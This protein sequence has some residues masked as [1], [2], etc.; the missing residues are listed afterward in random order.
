MVGLAL[1]EKPEH[2]NI[3]VAKTNSPKEPKH[4][5]QIYPEIFAS[6]SFSG[7]SNAAQ[8]EIKNTVTYFLNTGEIPNFIKAAPMLFN[9]QPGAPVQFSYE[10]EWLS[11]LDGDLSKAK[12]GIVYV[13]RYLETY[14]V[15]EM[16]KAEPL[17][18]DI[19]LRNV[20]NL[21]DND[22]K[23]Q[24]LNYT[25]QQGRTIKVSTDKQ[26]LEVSRQE[27]LRVNEELLNDTIFDSLKIEEESSLKQ[28]ILDEQYFALYQY[29]IRYWAVENRADATRSP[30]T[31]LYICCQNMITSARAITILQGDEFKDFFSKFRP[32][33]TNS[34]SFILDQSE[35]QLDS[36]YAL[37]ML[38]RANAIRLCWLWDRI[39]IE[40][41]VQCAHDLLLPITIFADQ[42]SW[43][44]YMFLASIHITGVL[45]GYFDARKREKELQIEAKKVA[46]AHF[47]LR[48][49]VLINDL[50]WG[51]ANLACCF[52]LNGFGIYGYYGDLV[53][54]ILLC[55]DLAS[56]L[57]DYKDDR[58]AHLDDMRR[59]NEQLQV[60]ITRLK[61]KAELNIELCTLLNYLQKLN[62]T[63]DADQEA[64]TLSNLRD[65]LRHLVPE[66][67]NKTDIE[68][69]FWQMKSLYAS[70]SNCANDWS[71]R[72]KLLLSDIVCAI[73]LVLTFSLLCCFYL[74]LLPIAFPTL[75]V[76]LGAFSLGGTT[77]LWRSANSA[78]ECS[79]IQS[80]KKLIRDEFDELISDFLSTEDESIV[81]Q[82][83]LYLQIL[84]SGAKVGYQEDKLLFT[85]LEAMRTTANSILIPLSL[86][87]TFL[88]APTVTLGIP[89]YVFVLL[90]ALVAAVVV[91]IFIKR[92]YKPKESKWIAANGNES[93]QPVL[94][95]GQ[96][97]GDEEFNSFKALMNKTPKDENIND[98]ILKLI[99]SSRT[100]GDKSL[101]ADALEEPDAPTEMDRLL[102]KHS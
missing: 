21:Q 59:Y 20:E 16:D 94:S 46:W 79:S 81:K 31:E 97:D 82:K 34:F 55:M 10:L 6:Y 57:W 86:A 1:S 18:V 15:K 78:I 42:V 96:E 39:V 84:Q 13:S 68:I 60:L 9:T 33:I 87:M 2:A 99:K 47:K 67:Q 76:S 12:P 37:G 36:D 89:T 45:G 19:S 23:Q 7:L 80:T 43:S 27:V 65:K 91:S 71:R 77:L 25:A 26:K 38:R 61:E 24:I 32:K 56:T 63:G 17:L 93:S 30:D 50:V 4:I 98:Q 72:Q 11:K 49:G 64:K 100:T 85:R 44:L 88:F 90:G 58:R 51:F 28:A 3:E 69:I 92:Y 62:T 74:T 95:L 29:L 53:T 75:M 22:L 101:F 35:E 54:G 102:D 5:P 73:S 40:M 14:Y 52:W 41:Y 66:T 83:Q 70:R 48:R 8:T